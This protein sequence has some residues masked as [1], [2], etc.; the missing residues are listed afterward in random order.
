MS[1]GK[2]PANTHSTPSNAPQS[3]PISL[4]KAEDFNRW[5]GEWP[6]GVP[7][8]FFPW[9][10][11]KYAEPK[12]SPV[13]GSDSATGQSWYSSPVQNVTP[14]EPFSLSI[15]I[16]MPLTLLIGDQNKPIPYKFI[17]QSPLHLSRACSTKTAVPLLIYAPLK[18]RR[19]SITDA[20]VKRLQAP[21][22]YTPLKDSQSPTTQQACSLAQMAV[23]QSGQVTAPLSDLCLPQLLIGL[24]P[25][26]EPSVLQYTKDVME[27]EATLRQIARLEE[28]LDKAKIEIARLRAFITEEGQ[29]L[30]DG[31]Q[32]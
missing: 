31:L 23:N 24:D 8:A 1:V 5:P 28:D 12:S 21:I 26:E 20:P 25:E 30:L 27:K 19:S 13:S 15:I 4:A 6:E 16:S 22:T 18:R 9:V 11:P 10:Y 2:P 17:A 3:S 14:G 29:R 32:Y 7:K